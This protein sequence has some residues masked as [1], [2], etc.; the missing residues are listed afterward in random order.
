MNKTCEVYYSGRSVR[1]L[2]VDVVKRIE[3]LDEETDGSGTGHLG[4]RPKN[5]NPLEY[6]EDFLINVEMKGYTRDC[7]YLQTIIDLEDEMSE[8]DLERVI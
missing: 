2:V 5:K 8:E 1:N 4:Q 7:I 3:Q 6:I